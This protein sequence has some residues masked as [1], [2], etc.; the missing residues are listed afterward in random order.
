MVVL[1]GP[2]IVVNIVVSL[3]LVDGNIN[4]LKHSATQT[5]AERINWGD[6]LSVIPVLGRCTTEL[7][8]NVGRLVFFLVNPNPD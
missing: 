5:V 1:V 8:G 2:A 6:V 4:V 3:S 7:P